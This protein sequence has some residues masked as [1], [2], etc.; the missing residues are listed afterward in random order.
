MPA[1]LPALYLVMAQ[2]STWRDLPLI[3]P[4]PIDAVPAPS[5]DRPRRTTATSAALTT[6]ALPAVTTTPPLVPVQSMVIDLVMVTAPKLPASTHLIVPP[7]SVAVCAA[8][9]VAHGAARVQA[10]PAPLLATQVSGMAWAGGACRQSASKAPSMLGNAIVLM[11]TPSLRVRP[12]SRPRAGQLEPPS[13][14]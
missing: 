8:A 6:M 14:G 12:M 11:G 1:P 7:G 13:E 2:F 4:T 9:N 3:S 5:I 10:A